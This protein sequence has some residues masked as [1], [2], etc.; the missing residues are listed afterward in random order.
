MVDKG[1]HDLSGRVALITGG[2][3][4]MGRSMCEVMAE[5][6]A[7]VAIADINVE[8]AQETSKLIAKFGH[9]ILTIK[10]DVSNSREVEHMVNE[11]VAKL[12]T[13]DIL[14]NNAGFVIDDSRIHEMKEEIWDKTMAVNLRGVFLCTRA[15]L[16]VM[17]KQKRGSII[18]MASIAGMLSGVRTAA[19]GVSKAGVINFTKRTAAEYALDGIRANAIAP[20]QIGGTDFAAGLMKNIPPEETAK[21]MAR[22]PMGRAGRP[23]EIKGIALYLA[24]DASS[25][26]TGQVFVIDAGIS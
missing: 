15:V 11:T 13:I 23:D 9:R 7:D 20:G 16:P 4:G 10:T 26:A 5:Y 18:N 1:M 17:M 2:G 6:G 25:Y 14:V 19:Y 12:G 3:Y 8:R 24:S 22:I 21:R